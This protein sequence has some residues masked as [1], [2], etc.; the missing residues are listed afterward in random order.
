MRPADAVV[1]DAVVAFGRALREEGIASGVDQ[2][3]VLARALAELDLRRREHVYWA[4]RA[5]FVRNREQLP[6]FERL[7]ERFWAGAR[8]DSPG[9]LVAEHGETD[10]RVAGPQHGGSSLPQFRSDPGH[11]QLLDAEGARTASPLEIPTAPSEEQGREARR[12]LL[13]AYSPNEVLT[14]HVPLEVGDDEVAAARRL[15]EELRHATPKRLSRRL[16]SGDLRRGRLDIRSTV[17]RSLACEGE[18]LRPVYV[19]RRPKPRRLLF[20][21]DVSGSMERYSRALLTSLQGAV[22]AGGKTEAFVFATR[23][24]RL[25]GSLTGHDVARALEDAKAAVPDWSGGTRIGH[26]LEDLRRRYGGLGLARGA[27]VVIASDGWDRGDPD[28]LADE[29][30]ALRLQCRRIVWLN[31]RPSD[32]GRQPLA[33]GMQTALPFVDDYVAGHDPCAVAALARLLGRVGSG[34]PARRQRA[35]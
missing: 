8:L 27:I 16:S 18:P 34:R 19:T 7:F 20:L 4:T 9:D 12:G 32:L 10:P 25:T 17:K 23:L 14:E 29:L 28:L 13:A 2:E 11:T 35:R 3:L 6:A 5:T 30:A 1:A 21:C 15:A 24:T 31:P 33:I 26:A 22:R